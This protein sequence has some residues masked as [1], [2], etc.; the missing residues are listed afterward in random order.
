M[1]FCI[2]GR[3][4]YIWFVSCEIKIHL[5]DFTIL[6]EFSIELKKFETFSQILNNLTLKALSTVMCW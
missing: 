4:I 1:F 6:G 3:T 5:F 2:S